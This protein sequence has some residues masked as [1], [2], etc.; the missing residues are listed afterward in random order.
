MQLPAFTRSIRFRLTVWYSSLLLVFGV[1]FVLALNIA[2]RLDQPGTIYEGVQY[3]DIEWQPVRTGPGQA[4]TGFVPRL[5]ENVTLREAED[6][7]YSENIDRLR[8]WSLLSV[9]G[10]ALASGVGGYVLSGMML[11][12]VRD[13]TQ[14]ASEISAT[15]LNRRIN[16]EG[17]QDELWD[18][19]QT[20]DSMIGR[21]EHSFD[22]QRQFVQDA[23]HELRT[24]L[25]AIR[26]NIEVTE[27]DAEA[28][29]DEYRE[30]LG[31]IKTQTERLTRLSEDLLLLTN[32]DGAHVEKEPVDLSELGMEVLSQLTPLAAARN[33]KLVPVMSAGVEVE[34]S[35]DL[36]YRCVLNL[37]DNAI[38]Y[39]GDGSTV[40][41]AVRAGQ[42]GG[43]VQVADNGVGI[44]PEDL[45][46]VFDRFY[47]TDK[48]RS[49]REG[50]TGLG[51]SIVKELVES[52]GGTVQ[53]ESAPGR[54][55]SFTV[56]LPATAP[57]APT[58]QRAAQADATL[59]FEPRLP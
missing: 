39:S 10:L 58:R 18:L 26:T 25:A 52:L 57:Q 33:V 40:T 31:T 55:T 3:N 29:P 21:L 8:Y 35:P 17:P 16:Y 46:R 51:L 36:M 56:S 6:Q 7:I 13:I 34:T 5:R 24:P 19:A 9:V 45:P 50:G 15:N 22:R 43:V 47:R 14:A 30:L 38:K 49:R 23:S 28:T 12:P 4:I 42:G 41:L 48:G 59:T 11:R 37:V 44:A 53:A 20:F 27:M 32:D 1:A 2:V 54:G